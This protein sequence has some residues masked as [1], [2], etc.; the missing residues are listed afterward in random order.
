M[1][2]STH[3]YT[4]PPPPWKNPIKY[5]LAGKT[6]ATQNFSIRSDAGLPVET[7]ALEILYSGQFT[8]STQLIKPYY[9]AKSPSRSVTVAIE[10]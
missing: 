2:E 9:L 8:L 5:S 4:F 7:S 3:Q 10:T 6:H 1:N